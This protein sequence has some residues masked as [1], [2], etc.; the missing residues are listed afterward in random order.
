[1]AGVGDGR[2]PPFAPGYFEEERRQLNPSAPPP[3]AV[4]VAHDAGLTVVQ[5]TAVLDDSVVSPASDGAQFSQEA[6]QQCSRL[7]PACAAAT[8]V[9]A[10]VVALF[11]EA[12]FHRCTP[13]GGC[14]GEFI[15]GD[16]EQ[17]MCA[18]DGICNERGTVSGKSMPAGCGEGGDAPDSV[19]CD[20]SPGWEGTYCES[21]GPSEIY[22]GA[23]FADIGCW[24]IVDRAE[25]L[26]DG[27]TIPQMAVDNNGWPHGESSSFGFAVGAVAAVFLC[28]ACCVCLCCDG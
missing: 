13:L 9:V 10:V 28:V 4:P 19:A 16:F 12:A 3:L 17:L 11:V 23:P 8:V 14:K 27:D 20:C 1:M 24:N 15:T 22:E 6:D 26:G 5:A 2:P 7:F 21:C 18:N 25:V